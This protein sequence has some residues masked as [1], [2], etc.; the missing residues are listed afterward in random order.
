MTTFSSSALRGRRFADDI[1]DEHFGLPGLRDAA[2][3]IACKVRHCLEFGTH[4][5]FVGEV[6]GIMLNE[7]AEPLAWARAA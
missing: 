6:T 5:L 2:A 1:W 3:S 4:E 7:E